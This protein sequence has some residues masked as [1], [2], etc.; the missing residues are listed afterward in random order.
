M[1]SLPTPLPCPG[2]TTYAGNGVRTP[3]E[4]RM[5]A[6]ILTQITYPTGGYTIIDYEGHQVA[7]FDVCLPTLTLVGGLRVKEIGLTPRRAS[8]HS[9]S[10]TNIPRV[11][12][13]R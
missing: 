12:V 13:Q 2:G 5:K 3:D 8:W 10:S 4:T 11:W 9:K 1:R 6:G 7:S